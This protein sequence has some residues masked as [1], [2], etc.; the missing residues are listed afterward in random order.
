MCTALRSIKESRF[1]TLMSGRPPSQLLSNS[2]S[3]ELSY[4]NEVVALCSDVHE[5]GD[6]A[7]LALAL[8]LTEHRVQHD[9]D[10]GTA[11]ARAAVDDNRAVRIP[12]HRR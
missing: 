6:K 10:A 11:D 7:Q 4:L 5:V 1:T 2:T 9:V 8:H 12:V 3:K